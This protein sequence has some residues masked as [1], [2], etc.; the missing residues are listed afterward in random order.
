M[1]VVGTREG[2]VVGT[3][4]VAVIALLLSLEQSPLYNSVATVNA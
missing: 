3:V 4:A 1:L 2:L